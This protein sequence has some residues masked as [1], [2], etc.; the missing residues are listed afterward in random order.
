M[1]SGVSA[2]VVQDL[3]MFRCREGWHAEVSHPLLHGLQNDFPLPG[4]EHLGV[5]PLMT[6]AAVGLVESL[7][8]IVGLRRHG[9]RLCHH[10][11]E[12]C[13]QVFHGNA[14]RVA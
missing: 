9:Q 2:Q 6:H 4:G 13:L 7:S 1:A 3:P 12:D 5:G 11:K 10:E 8:R 14:S